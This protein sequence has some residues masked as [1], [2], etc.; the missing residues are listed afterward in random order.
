MTEWKSK[1][2]KALKPSVQGRGICHDLLLN[3]PGALQA[4]VGP[5]KLIPGNVQGLTPREANDKCINKNT[6]RL[7][8]LFKDI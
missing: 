1:T 4:F 6:N 5:L 3:T 2:K 7:L 8:M